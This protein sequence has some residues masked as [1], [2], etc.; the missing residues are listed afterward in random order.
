MRPSLRRQVSTSATAL[1][2]VL[3]PWTIQCG[4]EPAAGA[5]LSGPAAGGGASPS[6]PSPAGEAAEATSGGSR[7]PAL[8]GGRRAEPSDPGSAGAARGGA[9][10]SPAAEAGSGDDAAAAGGPAGEPDAGTTAAAGADAPAPSG[11]TA[12]T[13]SAGLP[14]ITDI[15]ADGPF[16]ATTVNGTGPNGGYTLFHPQP[17]GQDG[18][19]HPYVTWGNGATTT[20]ELFT[21]LPRLATHGFVVIASNNAFVTSAEMSAGLDWLEA[22]NQR[23]D[24]ALYQQLDSARVASLGYSLGSLGTFEIAADPRLKTTVHISGGAMEKSVVP[25]LRNPAAFFCGDSSDIA[26]ENCVSD[27]ELATVPVFFGV[28]PGDHLGI[29]GAFAPQIDA[30]TTAWLRWR[31]MGDASLDAMFVGPEC[32]LCTNGMWTVKQKDLDVAP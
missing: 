21:L 19:K 29:L 18:F 26:N 3:L 22:E 28:F 8:D 17:L 23:A 1:V 14:A 27:F 13:P 15:A 25:N 20:P 4:D 24:S 9:G 10:G 12:V 7:A 30:A 32:T 2:I 16:T 5:T 6:A 31:L 11:G